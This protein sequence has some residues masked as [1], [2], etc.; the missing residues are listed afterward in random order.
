MSSSARPDGMYPQEYQTVSATDNAQKHS[1]T[2]QAT[3]ITFIQQITF[4]LKTS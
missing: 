3:R 1:I 4:S 2:S